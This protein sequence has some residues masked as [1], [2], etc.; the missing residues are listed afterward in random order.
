MQKAGW[1]HAECHEYAK[2]KK[3]AANLTKPKYTEKPQLNI[4]KKCS[5][6]LP[7]GFTIC[8][9][10]GT[11]Q[12]AAQGREQAAPAENSNEKPGFLMKTDSS[13]DIR[14]AICNNKPTY[15]DQ[16]DRWFCFNCEKWI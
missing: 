7:T 3:E 6:E 16:Y 5:Q 8:P 15:F 10:C 4:C 13:G 2:E 1:E 9:F 14:C 11:T 12:R